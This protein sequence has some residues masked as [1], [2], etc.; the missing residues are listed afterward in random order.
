M[1]SLFF[2]E[3]DFAYFQPVSITKSLIRAEKVATQILTLPTS[4]DLEV[5]DVNRI[6][7]MVIKLSQK[8]R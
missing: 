4:V 8:D 7:D 3:N 5:D 1:S 6:C 2:Y